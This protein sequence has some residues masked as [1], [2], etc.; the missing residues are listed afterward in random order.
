MRHVVRL[1]Q[2]NQG[3]KLGK[4]FE[5]ALVKQRIQVHVPRFLRDKVY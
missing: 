2:I 3:T 5:V 4:T 1:R